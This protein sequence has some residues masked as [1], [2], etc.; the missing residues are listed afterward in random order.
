MSKKILIIGAGIAGLS[1]GCYA[2]MNNYDTEIYES[3]SLPGGLCTA[4]KRNGY[5][6]DGCIHWLTGS[7]PGG[8]FYKFWE[9]L[10]AVQNRKMYNPQV[11]FRYVDNDNRIFNLYSDVNRLEKHMIELSPP[12]AAV[13]KKF[14]ALIRVFSSM[15]MDGIK[16][17]ELMNIFDKIKMMKNLMPVMKEFAYCIKTSTREFAR[18]FKDRLLYE[19]IMNAISPEGS[20]IALIATMSGFNT[21]S[22]GFPEGGSLEFAKTIEKRYLELGG[23]IFYGKKVK[24]IS[25]RKGKACGLLLADGSEITGDIIISG[26]D[27]KTL[28]EEMLDRK[29]NE[30]FLYSLFDKTETYPTALQVSFGIN[31]DI[32]EGSDAV[33]VIYSLDSP[34]EI[35]GKMRRT[36]HIKNYNFDKTMAPPGKTFMISLINTDY[37]YWEKLFSKKES[38]KKEKDKIAQ[39]IL[40][41]IEKKIPDIRDHVEVID[42]AT[43]MTYYRYTGNW[44]GRFMTWIMTPHNARKLQNIPRQI[45][46]LKNFYLA[47]MWVTAPGGLPSGVKSGREAVQMICKKDHRKFVAF[48][49]YLKSS[50]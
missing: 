1:A 8:M 45:K 42:V 14:C 5:T 2:R 40:K 24:R 3:Q 23:K 41:E 34:I 43:P 32:T 28:L 49:P 44:K 19:G 20:L 27:L 30:T 22:N 46:G 21:A 10:G 15:K 37:D 29:Y 7:A 6:I 39:L 16:A 25:V 36:L 4:W 47:G 11:Y 9:E 48:K 31:K 38:Y 35:A 17:R 12:D 26:S 18:Q 33:G 13:S 50:L